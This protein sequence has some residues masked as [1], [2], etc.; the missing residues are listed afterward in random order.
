[1]ATRTFPI[2][3]SRFN[4]AFM[5]LLLMGP[6]RSGVTVSDDFVDVRMGWAFD[7]R[8]PRTQITAA[9]PGEKP[10]LSGWGVHGWGGTWTVNG[11]SEGIVKLTID[12]PVHA[13]TLVFAIKLH[14]LYVSLE[15]TAGLI[16]AL[17][18]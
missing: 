3:Y 9:A 1:M 12:P 8:I 14:T 17:E 16:A 11:S 18:G 6:S 10:R 15:D 5:S 7:A 4:R 13:R 2:S